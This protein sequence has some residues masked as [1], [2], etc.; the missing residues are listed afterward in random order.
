MIQVRG[1]TRRFDDTTVV[2]D[3]SFD[4]PPGLL[5]GFVGS[6]RSRR[7]RCRS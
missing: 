3:V 2:D 5:T 6:C 4:V 1:L 7:P